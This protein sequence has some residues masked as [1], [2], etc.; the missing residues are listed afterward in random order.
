MPTL[1]DATLLEN[2][3]RYYEKK[4]RELQQTLEDHFTAAALTGYFA[5][6]KHV[7]DQGEV[8]PFDRSWYFTG[9]AHCV[10]M[11]KAMMEARK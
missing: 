4:V 2:Q 5:S 11:G 7:D 9:A 1:T 3:V 8:L 10:V 6:L